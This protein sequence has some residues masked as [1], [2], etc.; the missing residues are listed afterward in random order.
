MERLLDAWRRLDDGLANIERLMIVVAVIVMVVA[1]FAQSI[2][3]FFFDYNL[4]G[5]SSW[6][7]VLLVWVGFISAGMAAREKKHIV[8]DII[9][10]LLTGKKIIYA[11]SAAVYLMTAIFLLYVMQACWTYYQSPGVQFRAMI[12]VNLP[13]QDDPLPTKYVVVIMPIAI[14]LTA[15]RF[16]QVALE[17]FAIW[18]GYYPMSKRRLPPSIEDLVKEFQEAGNSEVKS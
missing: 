8:V 14:G 4:Y 18:L 7:T 13:W 17:E 10:K 12:G 2:L 1:I 11:L 15:L 5:A 6:A 3:R 9:P 16:V